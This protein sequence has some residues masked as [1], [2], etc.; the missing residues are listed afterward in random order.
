M[1]SFLSS[2][3]PKPP[4]PSWLKWAMLGFIA[5]AMLNGYRS[6]KGLSDGGTTIK[7]YPLLSDFISAARWQLLLDPSAGKGIE[8][9]QLRAGEGDFAG[10]GQRVTANIKPIATQDTKLPEGFELPKAPV[11]FV[12]GDGSQHPILDRGVRGMHRG[13][14]R[15]IL[16]GARWIDDAAPIDVRYPFEIELLELEPYLAKP[17]QYEAK[18]VMV[19][20]GVPA[21]CGDKVAL[22]LE[23][24]GRQEPIETVITLGEGALGHGIDRALVGMR[25]N[26]VKQLSVPSEYL[27]KDRSVF[28]W[29]TSQNLLA[30]ITRLP[31]TEP[32]TKN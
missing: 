3:R 12:V 9:Q 6:E 24:Q 28:P 8:V 15:Q 1:L 17:E 25:P 31:Y 27:P 7:N 26:G 4:T 30:Q 10:C 32:E 2:N 22:R 21:L 11:S 5:V 20:A 23:V 29:L 19:S 13:E 16:A 18:F 14:Q